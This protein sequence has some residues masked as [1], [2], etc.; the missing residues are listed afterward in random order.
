[1]YNFAHMLTYLFASDLKTTCRYRNFSVP[2]VT[3]RVILT[4]PS[5]YI[6]DF[7]NRSLTRF[8]T[9]GIINWAYKIPF[10]SVIRKN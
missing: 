4:D 1:M 10:T 5:K 3:S 2:Y 6:F 8:A 7:E 9:L